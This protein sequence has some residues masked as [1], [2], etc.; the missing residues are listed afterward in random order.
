M[1][2][3]KILASILAVVI[4]LTIALPVTVFAVPSTDAQLAASDATITITSPTSLVLDKDDFTAY[5][6][7]QVAVSTD[8][9]NTGV[10]ATWRDNNYAYYPADGLQEFLTWAAADA[11]AQK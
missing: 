8:H 4:M 9:Q 3:R 6:L 1:K 5:L 2:K 7:F 11:N 10:G